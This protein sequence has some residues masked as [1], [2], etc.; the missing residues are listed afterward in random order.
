MI[1]ALFQKLYN[2]PVSKE[3]RMFAA[4]VLGWALPGVIERLLA[5]RGDVVPVRASRI[6]ILAAKLVNALKAYNEI[7][8]PATLLKLR[9]E[10]RIRTATS[11]AL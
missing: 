4:L 2:L 11:E 3:I 10:L 1:S 6:Q 7:E 5:I 9:R 8:L